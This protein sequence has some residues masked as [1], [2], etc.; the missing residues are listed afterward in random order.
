MR[1]TS[2]IILAAFLTLCIVGCSTPS[3]PGSPG[4][5]EPIKVLENPANGER[6][7]FFR[8]IPFKAPAGYDESKAIAEWTADKNKAG[9]TK[10]ITPQEDREKLA[11][12]RKKNLAAKPAP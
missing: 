4:V 10:E 12:L 8:E 11:E 1:K 9:F 6:E 2:G 3:V 5:P 7:R